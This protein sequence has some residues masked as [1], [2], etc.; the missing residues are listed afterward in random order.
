MIIGML[1]DL[2][3]EYR[4]ITDAEIDSALDLILKVFM[5]FE[6]PDYTPEGVKSFIQDVIK[7]D[8]FRE[9]IKE[10]NFKTFV[11]TCNGDVVGVMTLRKKTHIMLAFVQKEYQKHGIGRELFEY[12]LQ[13]ICQE[14]C[15]SSAITVNSSP[16]AIGFYEK[17]G[18]ITTSKEQEK[19]GIRSV[20]MKYIIGEK[21]YSANNHFL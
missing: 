19:H 3:I 2:N 6:A 14:S 7:N 18:F 20:P 9:G 11:A 5:E 4:R 17:L 13:D 15:S 12:A 8:S 16:Y 1:K 21:D 10:D